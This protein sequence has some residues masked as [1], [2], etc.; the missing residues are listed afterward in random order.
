VNKKGSG[1]SRSDEPRLKCLAEGY[2]K[3]AH[4]EIHEAFN[5]IVGV[6]PTP[7]T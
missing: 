1:K 5:L 6:N 7:G 4:I 3:V 2:N